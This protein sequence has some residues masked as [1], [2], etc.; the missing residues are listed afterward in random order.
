M[1]ADVTPSSLARFSCLDRQQHSFTAKRIF[2]LAGLR[3]KQQQQQQK[4]AAFAALSSPE[5]CQE[6][7]I[8]CPV[9]NSECAHTVWPWKELQVLPEQHMF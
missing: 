5:S 9:P 8:L 7:S 1:L 3:L 6:A 2:C 4:K